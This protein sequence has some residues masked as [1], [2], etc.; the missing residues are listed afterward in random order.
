MTTVTILTWAELLSILGSEAPKGSPLN[1]APAKE[2][3]TGGDC[4]KEGVRGEFATDDMK[5]CTEQAEPQPTR[6]DLYRKL[7]AELDTISK[8]REALEQIQRQEKSLWITLEDSERAAER[9]IAQL[10]GK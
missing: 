8:H 7:A 3:A 9:L 4:C 2:K 1:P 10:A 5:A 6:R